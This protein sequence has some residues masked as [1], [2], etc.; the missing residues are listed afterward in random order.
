M[1][2]GIGEAG[3][4]CEHQKDRYIDACLESMLPRQEPGYCY[5]QDL[6]HVTNQSQRLRRIFIH[7]H[8]PMP[9]CIAAS[10]YKQAN[11][12]NPNNPLANHDPAL[13][14]TY[15]YFSSHPT[16]TTTIHFPTSRTARLF[17]HLRRGC[18][19]CCFGRDPRL[20]LPPRR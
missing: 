9:S 10:S 16:T 8:P 19:C 4:E 2:S 20:H 13:H 12:R 17:L 5:K 6:S 11:P 14:C 7:G 3:G 15:Y 18:C 1:D